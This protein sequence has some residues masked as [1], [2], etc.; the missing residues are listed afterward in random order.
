M[1]T[2]AIGDVQG[3]LDP[4]L[5]LLDKVNF[6][7]KDDQLWFAGDLVNRGHNSL[8]VLRLVKGLGRAAI[9]VLG[10]HD[11]HLLA[12]DAG[13]KKLNPKNEM[14][15]I[16]KAPDRQEL[17]DWL[18]QQPLVYHDKK[19]KHTIVHAGIPPTWSIREAL[20]YSAE[21]E[22]ALQSKKYHTY[23]KAMYGDTPDNWSDELQGETRLRV[24]TNYLTRMRFC[25][26]KGR[27]ELNA[28]LGP[29]DPPK[30]FAP[31][32][33][34]PSHRCADKNIIF[35]HWAA[36]QGNTDSQN[37]I[38]LDTGC[39]WGEKLTAYRLEDGKLFSVGCDC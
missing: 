26:K 17:I 21:V 35:G 15:R 7:R 11:L 29:E 34:H 8:G 2:Y 22:K 25:D 23:L 30:G 33:K 1:A 36:L 10:N 5:Q 28:N 31:W 19:L 16:L 38:G 6:S 27:L 37:F 20:A 39:V 4:L 13:F 32:F 24:I 12:I 3:C 9:T 14:A 18:R